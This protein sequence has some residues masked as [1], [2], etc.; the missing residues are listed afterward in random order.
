MN[1]ILTNVIPQVKKKCKELGVK[2]LSVFGS[3]LSDG[4]TP[5]S[6]VDFLIAFD[7]KLSIEEY[8]N[9]YFALHEFLQRVL[10]RKVDVLTESSLNNPFF[11]QQVNNTKQ[12]VYEA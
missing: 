8:T 5:Q 9:N 12:L 2:R 7:E 11:I 1:S 10:N 6:D 3:V 4:F